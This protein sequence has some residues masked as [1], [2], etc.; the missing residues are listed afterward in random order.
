MKVQEGRREL[1]AVGESG[2]MQVELV[3]LQEVWEEEWGTQ[4]R[5]G[6]EQGEQTGGGIW[7]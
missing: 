3:G 4:W 6:G 1:E 2:E 5:R 7:K